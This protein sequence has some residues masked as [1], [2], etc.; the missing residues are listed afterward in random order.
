[1]LLE[2]HKEAVLNLLSNPTLLKEQVNF[3]LKT[4]KEYG[5]LTLISTFFKQS[6]LK[7]NQK[8]PTSL[9]YK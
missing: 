7:K 6:H 3:A 1:M 5:T 4:L 8:N 2:Q 9:H